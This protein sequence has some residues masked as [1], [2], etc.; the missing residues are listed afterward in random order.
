MY[1]FEFEF[2]E[3]K[4][5]IV[6]KKHMEQTFLSEVLERFKKYRSLGFSKQ[7]IYK[8]L[9]KAEL[10]VLLF[11]FV[12]KEEQELQSNSILQIEKADIIEDG[13]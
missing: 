8:M 7:T 2:Q 10:A 5:N 1:K 3:K 6:K 11:Y 12:E 13:K 9:N 4:S